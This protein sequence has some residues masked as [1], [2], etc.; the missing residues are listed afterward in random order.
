MHALEAVKKMGTVSPRRS[1][2]FDLK[3]FPCSALVTVPN[4]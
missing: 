4:F 1:I 2:D 3:G